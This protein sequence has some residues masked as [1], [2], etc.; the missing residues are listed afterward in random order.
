MALR[1]EAKLLK[2]SLPN[3][4]EPDQGWLGIKPP[5]ESGVVEIFHSSRPAHL[6][7]TA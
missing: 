4:L 2:V 6:S 3:P 1:N 7:L 5:G